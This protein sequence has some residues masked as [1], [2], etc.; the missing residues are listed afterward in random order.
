M[1][2][3]NSHILLNP[4]TA[5][6][7]LN[8]KERSIF[9]CT[10]WD[11]AGRKA[12]VYDVVNPSIYLSILCLYFSG[13]RYT[14][15]QCWAY[16]EFM[17]TQMYAI[18]MVNYKIAS[19]DLEWLKAQLYQVIIRCTT[20]N[21]EPMDHLFM[22]H[23]GRVLHNFEL[24]IQPRVCPFWHSWRLNKWHAPLLKHRERPLFKRLLILKI[25]INLISIHILIRC[26]C[27]GKHYY[28]YSCNHKW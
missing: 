10:V 13:E 26:V 25:L 8:S 7:L 28:D 1:N 23:K 4:C 6:R 20:M 9:L 2:A 5:F 16:T 14:G 18:V 17:P 24:I 12:S 22:R 21:T 19:K 3:M 11:T 15:T 27:K